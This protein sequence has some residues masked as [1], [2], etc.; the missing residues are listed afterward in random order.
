MITYCLHTT[1]KNEKQSKINIQ[2]KETLKTTCRAAVGA[3]E[4]AGMPHGLQQF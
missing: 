2:S 1:A 3:F 4:S